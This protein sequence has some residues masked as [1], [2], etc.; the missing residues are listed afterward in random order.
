MV[1]ADPQSLKSQLRETITVH[2][3][4]VCGEIVRA[5]D[6]YNFRNG[7]SHNGILTL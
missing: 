4:Y 5:V 1:V 3:P 2:P 7:Q 6:R